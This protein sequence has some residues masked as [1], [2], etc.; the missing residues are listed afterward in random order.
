MKE[1]PAEGKEAAAAAPTTLCKRGNKGAFWEAL[2]D[3]V[4]G[5]G[6]N[7]ASPW[8]PELAAAT[9]RGGITASGPPHR[10]TTPWSPPGPP[11]AANLL[12]CLSSYKGPGEGLVPST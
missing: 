6:V 4:A 11:H 12:P 1:A 8:G 9:E 3:E 5:S 10:G 2:E 7:S